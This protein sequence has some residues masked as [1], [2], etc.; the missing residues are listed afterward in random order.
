MFSLF[1]KNNLVGKF[2]TLT[3]ARR[4]AT[5]RN[6]IGAQIEE[7]E[8]YSQQQ[9][10]SERTFAKFGRGFSAIP[11]AKRNYRSRQPYASVPTCRPQKTQLLVGR[12][13][14]IPK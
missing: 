1:Y 11:R 8:S 5:S 13:C 3:E 14:V 10:Q 6:M 4:Y 2:H 7:D 9:P 12:R